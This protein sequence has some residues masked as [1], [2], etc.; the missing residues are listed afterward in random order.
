MIDFEVRNEMN[1]REW[2][3]ANGAKFGY[4]IVISQ[5]AFPDYVLRDEQGETYRVEVEF[6]SFNFVQHKHELSGC[7]F[8]LCWKHSSPMTLPVLELVT[9]KMYQPNEEPL[10]YV[11]I[12]KRTQVELEQDRRIQA[13]AIVML[14]RDLSSTFLEAIAADMKATSEYQKLLIEPRIKLLS[15]TEQIVRRLNSAGLRLHSSEPYDL[16]KY[17]FS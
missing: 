2:F 13:K 17:L 7:D 11:D 14:E 5:T 9:G 1:V 6:D 4:T 12:G 10:G 8:I 3:A 16:F 15:V